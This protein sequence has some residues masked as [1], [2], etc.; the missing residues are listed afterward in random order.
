MPAPGTFT[1]D[2]RPGLPACIHYDA[3]ILHDAICS[4]EARI[5]ARH[6]ALSF[7][8]PRGT[9]SVPEH[10][11][12][13]VD[14]C[15]AGRRPDLA[16]AI[17]EALLEIDARRP[18]QICSTGLAIIS[19]MGID[20][21]TAM[22]LATINDI[23]TPGTVDAFQ[24]VSADGSNQFWLDLLQHSTQAPRRMR[25]NAASIGAEA[26]WFDEHISICS[27]PETVIAQL[28]GR[29]LTD[30]IEHPVLDPIGFTIID[31]SEEFDVIHVHIERGHPALSCV[32]PRAPELTRTSQA[33]P[34][35][36]R[37]P[38]LMSITAY[39]QGVG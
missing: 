35:P 30:L 25:V 33:V 23:G 17:R 13:T 34:A 12:L 19:R 20:I 10:V 39:L 22:L 27:L 15:L 5:D 16:P 8:L 2:R 6:A 37:A 1:P 36:P 38:E 3:S 4:S 21:P 32:P 24:F 31:T 26:F 18:A 28:P 9:T 11:L 7:G 29:P 14:E